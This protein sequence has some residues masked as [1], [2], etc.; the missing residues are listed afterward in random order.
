MR[1]EISAA[2]FYSGRS[3]AAR[4]DMLMAVLQIGPQDDA[5]TVFCRT[6][7][8]KAG[9]FEAGRNVTAHRLFVFDEQARSAELR[10]GNKWWN[11]QGGYDLAALKAMES[12]FTTLKVILRDVYMT[13]KRPGFGES[14]ARTTLQEGLEQVQR[15]P[16]EA[17]SMEAS[18]SFSKPSRNGQPSPERTR[19]PKL[20]S[21]QK[22]ALYEKPDRA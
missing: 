5:V 10:E 14:L 9:Q 13:L 11:A 20:S 2:V 22:R 1:P 7:V 12:N 18:P 6:A 3:F 19:R 8:K 15:L 21:A 16:T 17:D 4:R